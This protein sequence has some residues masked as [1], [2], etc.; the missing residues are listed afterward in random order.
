MEKQILLSECRGDCKDRL[1]DDGL[2]EELMVGK[3]IKH[4]DVKVVNEN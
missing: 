1:V 3:E 2:F 4:V